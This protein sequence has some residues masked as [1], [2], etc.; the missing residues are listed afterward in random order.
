M[1]YSID[2]PL[3]FV[4]RT[5]DPTDTCFVGRPGVRTVQPQDKCIPAW[6]DNGK[7][8]EMQPHRLKS[9]QRAWQAWQLVVLKGPQTSGQL[10]EQLDLSV[11]RI[12][13]VCKP[14]VEARVLSSRQL[15]KPI[16]TTQY[17]L[18]VAPVV[19]VI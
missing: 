13:K 19:E 4:S 10:A 18:G 15:T 12:S 6:G 7:R 8:P 9:G 3:G 2:W 1:S 11:E 5:G 17:R 14:L 16:R